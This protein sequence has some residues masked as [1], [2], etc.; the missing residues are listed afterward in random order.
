MARKLSIYLG[1]QALKVIEKT[2][3]IHHNGE[4]ELSVSG[5]INSICTR[6]GELISRHMPAFTL[7]EWCAVC[8]ANNGSI[9]DD[10]PSTVSLLWAN[11]AD[12]EGIGHKWEIDPAKLIKKMR[13][14]DFAESMA[15]AEVVQRFWADCSQLDNAAWLKECGAKMIEE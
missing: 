8:D 14:L 6:Y 9:L 13:G 15:V 2:A 4:R 7:A 10:F 3:V 1:D 12:S 5:R 11:V